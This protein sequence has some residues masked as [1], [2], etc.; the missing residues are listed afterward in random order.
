MHTHMTNT[1]ITDAEVLETRYPVQLERF[2]IRRGSGGQGQWNGGDGLIRHYR[3]LKPVEVSL[4]TQRRVL[5]PF[6]LEGGTAGAMGR[7][8]RVT[9]SG[10]Q[11]AM[12][13]A[14]S[15]TAQAGEGLILKTPGGGGWGK[16]NLGP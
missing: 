12:S 14:A 11:V 7:N 15:F 2:A 3:F 13:G 1:R 6:G 16:R 5:E 8:L 10:E 4:L 9:G